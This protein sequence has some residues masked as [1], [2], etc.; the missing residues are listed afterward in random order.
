MRGV[1]EQERQLDDVEG[2]NHRTELADADA[3]QLVGAALRPIDRLLLAAELLGCVRL[4]A[5]APGGGVR[6]V[7]CDDGGI[8]IGVYV[9]RLHD[10]TGLC[11]CAGGNDRRGQCRALRRRGKTHR[12]ASFNWIPTR[13]LGHPHQS[14]C[15]AEPGRSRERVVPHWQRGVG[16]RPMAAAQVRI[17]FR[18]WLRGDSAK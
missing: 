13:V 6:F 12:V 4:D 1:A 9:E 18:Q 16:R 11:R 10:Q 3:R 2:V 17:D 7:A 8:A 5:D 14:F 15:V